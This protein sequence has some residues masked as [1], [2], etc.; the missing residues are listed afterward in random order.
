MSSSLNCY[1]LRVTIRSVDIQKDCLHKDMHFFEMALD[2]YFDI[3]W[4]KK[5]GTPALTE[6]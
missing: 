1:C 6:L 3:L 2:V 5:A 4:G